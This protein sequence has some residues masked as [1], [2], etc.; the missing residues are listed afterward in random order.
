MGLFDWFRRRKPPV[1][2]PL[3]PPV[4]VPPG[5]L[6]DLLLVEHNRERAVRGRK[7]LR[8]SVLLNL[9]AQKHS[10]DMAARRFMSHTGSDGSSPFQRM[11]RVGYQYSLAGENVAADH[12][13]VSEV[14]SGWM[15]SPG[16]RS[17]ILGGYT[18]VGFGVATDATGKI[19]WTAC[20]GVPAGD[21]VMVEEWFD[22]D[23]FPMPLML[24]NPQEV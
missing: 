23:S 11:K 2:N 20:F 6:V 5:N 19:Y 21:T 9:V 15:A 4:T 10:E 3:P 17:N 22:H 1:V 8:L 16:H 13:S 7:I 18:Q 24:T 14:M 12:R